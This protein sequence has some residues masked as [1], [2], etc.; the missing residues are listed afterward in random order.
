MVNLSEL[1]NIQPLNLSV[2][3]SNPDILNTAVSSANTVTGDYF[4]LGIGLALYIIM[5]YIATSEKSLFS[6]DFIKAS[7][8]SSAIVI[9]V[10]TTLLAINISSNFYHLMIFVVLFLVSLLGSYMLKDKE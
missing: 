9:V 2:N 4:G 3:L 10:M 8:F 5:I 6:F 7:L 1:A